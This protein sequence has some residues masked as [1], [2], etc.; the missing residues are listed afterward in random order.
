L[1]FEDLTKLSYLKIVD[2]NIK[3]LNGSVRNLSSLEIIDLSRNQIEKIEADMFLNTKNIETIY[4][5]KNRISVIER[6]AFNGLKKLN[7]LS[8]N[9]NQLS[10]L[11][12]IAANFIEVSFNKL[13]KLEISKTTKGIVAGNNRLKEIVCSKIMKIHGLS[14]PNNH[15]EDLSCIPKMLSLESL[16]VRGNPLKNFPK[17]LPKGL[18][19]LNSLTVDNMERYEDLNVCFPKLRHLYTDILRW[20]C[21]YLKHTYCI[22][23]SQLIQLDFNINGLSKEKQRQ[24]SCSDFRKY[25]DQRNFIELHDSLFF[26]IKYNLHFGF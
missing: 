26:S 16:T 2:N 8:L 7:R 18:K 17:G 22:L 25:V 4:M 21:S 12:P 14:V 9:F 6:G 10:V 20:N 3:E 23:R 1:A 19:D 5:E 15:F 11:P 24:L 13:V